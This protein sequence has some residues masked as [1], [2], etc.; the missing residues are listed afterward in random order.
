MKYALLIGI[1]YIG[2]DS[3]LNGCINDILNMKQVLTTTYGFLEENCVM[4]I[5]ND[6]RYLPPTKE[7]ILNELNKIATNT[8]IRKL[9]VHYSGHGSY[10]ADL[11]GD[12][13]DKRDEC[14]CPLDY[15]TAGF[16]IDDDLSQIFKSY[17][18]MDIIVIFDCCHSGTALDLPVLYDIVTKKTQKQ[19][20]NTFPSNIIFI[21][22]C[23]DTQTSADAYINSSA[24]GAMTACLLNTLRFYNFKISLVSLVKNMRK[25][26]VNNNFDQVPQLSVSDVKLA[27]K[28]GN[29]GFL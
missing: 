27:T 4:L 9:W 14:I 28:V 26:L 12:E 19:N 13:K 20:N 15:D 7:N 1:N 8:S 17:R 18:N 25:Y 23:K 5:E 10:V 24:Q 6:E 2:T 11:N 21:S 29:F 22:G 3:E 16:I